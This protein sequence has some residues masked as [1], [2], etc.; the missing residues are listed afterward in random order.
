MITGFV[1]FVHVSNMLESQAFYERLGL[2]LLSRFGPEGDPS[3]A[4]LVGYRSD[5]MLARASG[6]ID[7]RV[8]AV[9]FYLYT[10]NVKGLREQML[11]DGVVDG[12]TFQGEAGD[13]FPRSGKLFDITHPHHMP[14]GEMR[15]HDPDGYVLL[16]GQL[17]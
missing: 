14:A 1:P 13:D 11:A 15:V 7:P 2:E 6:P 17:N 10:P 16:I 8:Q 3:W 12:G 5:L 4:R 9:L